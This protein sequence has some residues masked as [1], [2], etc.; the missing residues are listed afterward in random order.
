MLIKL[1]IHFS[2]VSRYE[3]HRDEM[4][5]FAQGHHLS[6]GYVSTPPF[7]GFLAFLVR[8]VF[9]YS[10]LA[11]KF[12]PALAGAAS[13]LVIALFVRTM[14]GKNLALLLAAIG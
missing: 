2:I 14:G 7:V 1:I 10:Q 11:I 12:F 13:I 5:Y 4:L 9:G 6:M 8:I 3:L